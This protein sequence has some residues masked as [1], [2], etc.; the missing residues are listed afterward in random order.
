MW[1]YGTLSEIAFALKTGKPVVGVGTWKIEGVHAAEGA[2][3]AVAKAFGLIPG[4]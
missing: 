4:A 2:E 1:V 3:E